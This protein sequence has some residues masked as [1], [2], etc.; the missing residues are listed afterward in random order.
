MTDIKIDGLD[1]VDVI[2]FLNKK[3]DKFIAMMLSDMELVFK[4]D[5]KEYKNTR[6]VILD[7]MNDYTRSITRVL[8]GEIEGLQ[9]K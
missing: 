2:D 1:V 8:F 7:G 3:R 4:P 6:K 9:Q 5:S